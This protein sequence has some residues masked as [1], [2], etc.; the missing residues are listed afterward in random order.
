MYNDQKAALWQ[1]IIG[2]YTYLKTKHGALHVN[3]A[4]LCFF[5]LKLCDKLL[6]V[7]YLYNHF[8]KKRLK[9]ACKQ[10]TKGA[11]IKCKIK[12]G[13]T[14]RKHLKITQ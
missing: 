13:E 8:Q 5:L 7:F 6:E 3:C 10:L 1:I 14:P 12:K 2:N 4:M 11:S 9:N